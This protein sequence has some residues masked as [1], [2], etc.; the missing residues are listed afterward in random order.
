V[1]AGFAVNMVLSISKGCDEF[2]KGREKIH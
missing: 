2:S 1:N